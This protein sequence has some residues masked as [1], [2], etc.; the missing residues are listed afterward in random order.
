MRSIREQLSPED[1]IQYELEDELGNEFGNNSEIIYGAFRHR[2]PLGEKSGNLIG[3]GSV[4][5]AVTKRL[6]RFKSDDPVSNQ[7]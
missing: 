3:D 7:L 2:F 4:P 6:L 5:E 1:E